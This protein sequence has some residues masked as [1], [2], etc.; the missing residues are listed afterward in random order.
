[1]RAIPTAGIPPHR[2]PLPLVP[3]RVIASDLE[4]LVLDGL[5]GIRTSGSHPRSGL[6]LD[7]SGLR[8]P[9]FRFFPPMWFIL[10]SSVVGSHDRLYRLLVAC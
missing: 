10:T 9:W 8:L 6:E 2:R 5:L 1:M 4:E 7:V 3:V